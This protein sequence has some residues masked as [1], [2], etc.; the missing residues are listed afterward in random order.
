MDAD[1][2]SAA[3]GVVTHRTQGSQGKVK[4]IMDNF[5]AHARLPPL[6]LAAASNATLIVFPLT[7]LRSC[8][9]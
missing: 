2:T 7:P 8:S 3:V 4:P 5:G 1:Q 9:H 6:E